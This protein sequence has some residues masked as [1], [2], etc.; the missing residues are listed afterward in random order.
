MEEAASRLRPPP[1]PPNGNEDDLSGFASREF[2]AWLGERLLARLSAHPNWTQSEPVALGSWARGELTPKSDID[3]LFAGPEEVVSGLVTDLSRE[4]IKL[5]YRVP[6]DPDDWTVG[7]L[8]FD[9]LALFAAEPLTT[10][11]AEKLEEQQGRL[12]NQSQPFR[13]ELLRAM[14]AERKQRNERYDSISNFLEPNLK[15]GPGG[16]RD[17]EQALVTR[18]LFPERFEGMDHAFQVLD[19]YKHFFLLVRQKLHLAPGASDILAAP[20]QKPISDWLGFADP[21]DFMREIQKG[22]SRVSFYADWVVEQA[23][24]SSRKVREVESTKLDSVSSLFK[25]L[26]DDPGILMQNHVRLNADRVFAALSSEDLPKAAHIVGRALTKMIDPYEPEPMMVA[27]FRSRLIDHGVPEFRKIVGH[28]QHDQYHRFSVD[29]H[30]LQV[31]REMKRLK[32]NPLLAGKL[33]NLV[34]S[35]TKKE[36]EILAFAGLYHDIGK[37]REGDHSEIGKEIVKTDLARFGRDDSFVREVCW[38]VEQHLALSGAAF[39]GNP[40]SPETW[41]ILDEK[42]VTGRRLALLATFTI[43]DIRATNPE[44]W[45]TWKERLM[46]DLVQQLEKPEATS[47]LKFASELKRAGL[48]S[49]EAR[50]ASF[51]PFLVASV[52]AK[53]LIEDLKSLSA[54]KGTDLPLKVVRIRGGKQTWVRFH[55]AV[56]R[57]GLFLHYV[58]SLS[59]SGL[60]VR[61]A[62]ISTFPDIGVY[63]WFEVKTQKTAAQI[64]KLLGAARPSDKKHDVRFDSVELVSADENEWVVSFRG[65]DQS[66]ALTAAALAL[67]DQGAQIKWAKVHTWGRQIDDVFGVLPNETAAKALIERLSAKLVQA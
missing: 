53:V 27:L 54:P 17:L 6:E 38:I 41:K 3:L 59:A 46:F 13:K 67:F 5:R 36:W 1:S 31:L 2:S 60:S 12:L 50:L 34:R 43:V 22:V 15:F 56:D 35:L 28:V 55:S 61:H 24:Q 29:A 45:T 37:G 64:Q 49:W 48:K 11:A 4:G 65:R 33:S 9:V 66:G 14:R 21:K 23:S 7:V 32:K 58:R 30:L 51:D 25:A 47:L 16:L 39:R 63:D 8:P 10:K 40:R 18:D 42:G 26:E 20:E 44:A 52:P 19:Y 62:S 57:P